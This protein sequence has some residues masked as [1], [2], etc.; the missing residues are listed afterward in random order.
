MAREDVPGPHGDAEGAGES[1]EQIEH[2]AAPMPA[3]RRVGLRRRRSRARSP[4][5]EQAGTAFARARTRTPARTRRRRR[6]SPTTRGT[7]ASVRG[8]RRDRVHR[9]AQVVRAQPRPARAEHGPARGQ[10]LD[11]PRAVGHGQV[12]LHQAHRRAAVPRPGRRARARRLDPQ[13]V[14]RRPVRDAQE[15]RRAVPGRRPVRLDEPVRQRRLPAAPAHREGR[16]G[17]RRDRQPA[18]ERGRPRRRGREDAQRAV[19]RDAQARRLRARARART[20]TSCCS[21]SPTRAS[22]RCAPRCCAS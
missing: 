14:R 19:R 22:I 10:D 17:D 6:N 7:R 3:G 5:L 11:D 18:P 21:T 4:Q 12:G 16:R 8:A 1:Y 9:R 2:H 13:P 20:R 15:V